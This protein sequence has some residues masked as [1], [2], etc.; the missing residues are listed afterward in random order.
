MKRY[1]RLVCT[2]AILALGLPPLDAL[3]SQKLNFQKL[4]VYYSQQESKY[5]IALYATDDSTRGGKLDDSNLEVAIRMKSGRKSIVPRQDLIIVHLGSMVHEQAKRY[6]FFR[7]NLVIDNSSSIDDAALAQIQRALTR[8]IERLPLSFEGQIIRFSDDVRKSPFTKEKDDLIRWIREPYD[9]GQTA[10]YDAVASAIEELKYSDE[11]IPLKFS[12]VFTDGKNNSSVR[13]TDPNR[14]RDFVVSETKSAQIPLFIVGVTDE[15][16]EDLLR[17]I[18]GGFGLYQ[19][20]RRFPDV[21][22]AFDTIND[23][24]NDTYLF[25][26][27]GVSSLSEIEC[28]DIVRPSALGTG[29]YETI[30]DICL[31]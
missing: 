18:A 16:E 2:L 1:S 31:Q 29:K 12:V 5:Y 23:V 9:R 28:F 13:F 30:Q 20:V 24:I 4:A 15:V 10:L 8:F 19:H 6:T 11:T 27:P 26:V 7:F 3:A 22:K 21:D 14:F 25:K 17:A